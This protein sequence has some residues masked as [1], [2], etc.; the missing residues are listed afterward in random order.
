MQMA[1]SESER[2]VSRCAGSATFT[3]LGGAIVKVVVEDTATTASASLA[4]ESRSAL[5]SDDASTSVAV[6]MST[7]NESVMVM[8]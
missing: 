8:A 5:D 7:L 2:R 4:T 6:V 3:L 1:L